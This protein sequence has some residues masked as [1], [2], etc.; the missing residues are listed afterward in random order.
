[1]SFP[2]LKPSVTL[3]ATRRGPRLLVSACEV[4]H[5]LC[6]KIS[7]LTSHHSVL[8]NMA[9]YYFGHSLVFFLLPSESIYFW[10]QLILVVVG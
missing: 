8:Q 2:Y 7:A 3:H 1:M 10:S 5:E 9:L 6:L 4:I